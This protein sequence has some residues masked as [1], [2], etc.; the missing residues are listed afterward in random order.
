MV[1]LTATELYVANCGD[2]RSILRSDKVCLEDLRA[3][4]G[5]PEL[6]GELRRVKEVVLF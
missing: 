2:S 1:L 5:P 3:V 6:P 4:G